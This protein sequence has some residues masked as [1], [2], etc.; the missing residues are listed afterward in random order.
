LNSSPSYKILVSAYACHPEMGSEPGMGWN[1]ILNLAQH[2]ELWVLTEAE[3]FAPAMHA[4]LSKNPQLA[5]RIHVVGISRRRFGERIWPKLFYYFTYRQW[6]WD[7]YCKALELCSTVRF[8]LAH[9][10]NMIGYREPGYLWKLPLPFVW[11]PIGGHAQMPWRFLS[12]L[13]WRGAI[14]HALR[15]MLNSLQMWASLRVRNAMGRANALVAATKEDKRCISQIHDRYAVLISET[16]TDEISIQKCP[17]HRNKNSLRVI[18]SGV[19]VSRKALPL[20]LYAIERVAR[21]AKIE[22]WVLGSGP[23][24]KE[25]QWLCKELKIEMMCR[26]FGMI[27]HHEAQELLGTADILLF[28]SL[29]EATSTVVMEAIQAGLPVVCHDMCGFGTVVDETCGIKIPVI[30]PKNS[31]E[32]FA[33]AIQSLNDNPERLQELSR[34]AIKRSHELSWASKVE[35]M[36]NVYTTALSDY[37]TRGSTKR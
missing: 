37:Q 34:G 25:W 21:T 3:R 36:E 6:H 5:Q 11:G 4:F 7:A 13:G 10:L 2:H 35:L 24:E 27:S 17:E 29:Q 9:Q 15:N 1:W 32:G 33:S 18:W 22:L 19:F 30:D 28:T 12:F 16:G 31:I 20:A 26:W 8:D 14:E 23:L